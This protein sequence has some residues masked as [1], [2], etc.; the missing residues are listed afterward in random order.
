MPKAPE[1]VEKEKGFNSGI[2]AFIQFKLIQSRN[3]DLILLSFYEAQF[4]SLFLRFF[5]KWLQMRVDHCSNNSK[6]KKKKKGNVT[7]DKLKSGS[8]KRVFPPD[9]F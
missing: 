7:G 4:F 6:G 3:V 1:K 5:S 8:Y 9:W 2:S